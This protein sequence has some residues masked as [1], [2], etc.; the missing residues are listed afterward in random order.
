MQSLHKSANIFLYVH[1]SLSFD[2]VFNIIYS[3]Y[4]KTKII[5][6]SFMYA[7][8]LFSILIFKFHGSHFPTVHTYAKMVS[9][10]NLQ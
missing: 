1:T 7:H 3:P 2:L 10:H 9:S 5:D 8:V 4:Y 6:I